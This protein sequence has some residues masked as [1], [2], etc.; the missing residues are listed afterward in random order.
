M[1][2]KHVAKGAN[3]AA[4]AARTAKHA[5]RTPLPPKAQPGKPAARKERDSVRIAKEI[6]AEK[7]TAKRPAKK[8]Q[9]EIAHPKLQELKDTAASTG[10]SFDDLDRNAE[11][12]E[13][14]A[15]FSRGAENITVRWVGTRFVEA[16][17]SP[18][19]D[20]SLS[21]RNVSHARQ[22]MAV[23]ADQVR[24]PTRAPRKAVTKE[25][26]VRIA[27]RAPALANV[28]LYDL[29]A[30]AKGQAPINVG[31]VSKDGATSMQRWMEREGYKVTLTERK[32]G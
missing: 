26:A 2:T 6:V 25:A 9:P 18:V 10:W 19:P 27:R 4:H 23:P 24:V 14:D 31:P 30:R 29:K 32:V 16:F 20:R 12:S 5:Q 1:A 22:V 11:T 21:L 8:A 28:A 17:H 7:A 15:R 13:M 3:R